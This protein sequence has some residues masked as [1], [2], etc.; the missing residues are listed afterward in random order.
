MYRLHSRIHKGLHMSGSDTGA[1]NDGQPFLHGSLNDLHPLD[2][3]RRTA[4][5][6]QAA[7]PGIQ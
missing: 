3:A 6:E 5:G 2:S 1:R 7:H 4:T